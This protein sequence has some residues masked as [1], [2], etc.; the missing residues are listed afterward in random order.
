MNLYIKKNYFIFET[1]EIKIKQQKNVV[2]YAGIEFESRSSH[3][4]TLWVWVEFQTT[5]LHNQKKCCCIQ[6]SFK[7]PILY[8][9]SGSFSIPKKKNMS[10]LF[11]SPIAKT[12]FVKKHGPLY[13]IFLTESL[14]IYL[15]AS[16][17][18]T[19]LIE[20]TMNYN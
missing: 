17:C 11:F 4:F 8:P 5:K 7:R 16:M 10:I 20:L 13:F 1:K 19:W 15:V 14:F 9:N 2:V 6:I 12:M 3:L 18:W